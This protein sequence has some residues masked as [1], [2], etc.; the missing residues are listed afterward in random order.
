MQQI[1]REQ[2]QTSVRLARQLPA[3]VIKETTL[4]IHNKNIN[5]SSKSAPGRFEKVSG[6]NQQQWS[7]RRF[8]TDLDEFDTHRLLSA[9]PTYLSL[10]RQSPETRV[11]EMNTKTIFSHFVLF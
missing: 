1:N 6:K 8:Q 4:P 11:S 7:L 10:S 5:K 9:C 3:N 2:R